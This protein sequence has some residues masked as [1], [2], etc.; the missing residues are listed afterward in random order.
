MNFTTMPTTFQNGNILASVRPM[1]SGTMVNFTP[2]MVMVSKPMYP[3]G[4]L[5]RFEKL[6]DMN[7]VLKHIRK[8]PALVKENR[9]VE[10]PSIDQK[11]VVRKFEAMR[12]GREAQEKIGKYPVFEGHTDLALP[13]HTPAMGTPRKEVLSGMTKRSFNSSDFF[14]P[15]SADITPVK[16]FP[17]ETAV[18]YDYGGITKKEIME[19]LKSKDIPFSEKWKKKK[20]FDL[21]S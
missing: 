13:I 11:M 1:S 17:V 20:L 2:K 10:N 14:S 3:Q 21:L 15:R 5:S 12:M 16:L 19:I 7:D 9:P 18:G 6:P 4:H 8:R